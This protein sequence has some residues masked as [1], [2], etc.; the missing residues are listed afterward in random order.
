MTSKF[1]DKSGC[2]TPAVTG[3]RENYRIPGFLSGSR[4]NRRR[5]VAYAHHIVRCGH[6][7]EHSAHHFLSAVMRFPEIAEDCIHSFAQ[8]LIDGVGGM[9]GGTAIHGRILPLAVLDPMRR[10]IPQALLRPCMLYSR[11]KN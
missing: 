11:I 10:G 4:R 1:A 7:S 8:A 6:E 3:C 5:P 9:A 2:L